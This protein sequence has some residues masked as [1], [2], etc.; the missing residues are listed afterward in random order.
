MILSRSAERSAGSFSGTAANAVDFGRGDLGTRVRFVAPVLVTVTIKSYAQK[1]HF[2]WTKPKFTSLWVG[3][4]LNGVFL[5]RSQIG[6]AFSTQIASFVTWTEW[7]HPPFW[8]F[9]IPNGV[10]TFAG[11]WKTCGLLKYVDIFVGKFEIADFLW[12]I[13]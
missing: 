7:N 12:C 2:C 5:L 11:L 3:V 1:L 4:A 10:T 13:W 6:T 9:H 8:I